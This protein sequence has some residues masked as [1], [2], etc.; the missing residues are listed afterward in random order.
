MLHERHTLVPLFKLCDELNRSPSAVITKAKG[1]GIDLKLP[2]TSRYSHRP[3]R[4]RR[5][6]NVG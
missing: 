3:R 1:L 5:A 4:Q 6:S 2:P